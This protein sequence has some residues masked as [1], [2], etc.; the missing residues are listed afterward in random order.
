MGIDPRKEENMKLQNLKDLFVSELRDLYNAENQLVKALPKM[1]SS[2]SS[3]KLQAAFEEHLE[4][5]KNHVTRLESVF[6]KL[7]LNPKGKRCK[8][9]EGLIE[10]GKEIIEMR[11]EEP[12]RDAALI[13]A[14][15]RVEHYEIAGYG[16]VRAFA[17]L[18]GNEEAARV[19]EETLKEEKETDERLTE[20]AMSEI[21]EEAAE[22]VMAGGDQI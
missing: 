9:M 8:A 11:P 4:Q 14:A 19:L 10:E 1:A 5:T 7:N 3:E 12:V 6:E 22:P 20:L 16:C 2:A 15:Q 18:L 21:N 13:A 17:T